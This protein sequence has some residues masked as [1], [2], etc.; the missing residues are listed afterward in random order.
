MYPPRDW[1]GVFSLRSN[2][3]V[4]YPMVDSTIRIITQP[5]CS[6]SELKFWKVSSVFRQM[7][8]DH[9]R[10]F[11]FLLQNLFI[12]P[13]HKCITAISYSRVSFPTAVAHR[14]PIVMPGLGIVEPFEE[15]FLQKYP[16]IDNRLWDF[17]HIRIQVEF[18]NQFRFSFLLN[19]T[20][21]AHEKA[22]DSFTPIL[23]KKDFK[24]FLH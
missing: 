10:L 18:K 4:L 17:Y 5:F 2:D 19:R 16:L 14:N 13:F 23:S 12:Q 22:H 15:A 9:V 7:F 21:S 3:T 8:F 1:L 6:P 20:I 24:Q 11:R